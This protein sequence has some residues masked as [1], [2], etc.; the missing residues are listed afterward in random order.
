[1][2]TV[3]SKN[4]TRKNKVRYASPD[5]VVPKEQKKT[6]QKYLDASPDIAAARNM[7]GMTSL[8]PSIALAEKTGCTLPGLAAI[9]ENGQRAAFQKY[10]KDQ[11]IQPEEPPELWGFVRLA[12][13]ITGKEI[14]L[15]DYR[16]MEKEC[17]PNSKV[18]ELTK[19]LRKIMSVESA[20]QKCNEQNGDLV[21]MFFQLHGPIPEY[22]HK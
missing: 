13:A 8:V 15:D 16:I 21:D 12:R 6:L 11:T 14:G 20:K 3:A 1:M 4:K 7:Y 5:T 19:N 9:I 18:L 17:Q 10:Y 22:P 2:D